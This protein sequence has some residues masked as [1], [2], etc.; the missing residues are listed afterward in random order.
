MAN[1]NVDS[2]FQAPYKIHVEKLRGSNFRTIVYVLDFKCHFEIIC[3][4]YS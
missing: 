4:S 3:I 1:V 2:Q